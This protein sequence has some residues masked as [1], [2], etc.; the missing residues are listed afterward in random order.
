MRLQRWLELEHRAGVH[1]A[2]GNA[3]FV[4]QIKLRRHLGEGLLAAVDLGPSG[5][6]QIIQRAGFRHQ[7]LVLRH[8]A[9]KHRPHGKGEFQQLFRARREPEGEQP[10]RHP[11]QKGQM[12]VGFRR[13]LQP[14]AQQRP[15]SGWKGRREDRLAFEHARIAVGSFFARP[16]TVDER[17]RKP[18]LG[19]MQGDGG[20]DDAGAQND[21]V[22]SSHGVIPLVPVTSC[23]AR[24][25]SNIGNA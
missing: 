5:L 13:T 1:G 7:R 4:G 20:T 22:R 15:E 17:D 12:I 14:H 16:A 3:E 6:A 18:S 8:R 11:R 25:D 21:G 2:V 10:G 23:H 9:G 19:E 24:H